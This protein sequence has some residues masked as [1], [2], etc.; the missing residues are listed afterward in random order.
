MQVLKTLCAGLALALLS[1]T[2][3]ADFLLTGEFRYVDRRFT[4]ANGFNGAE[5]ERV[6]PFAVVNVLDGGGSTLVQTQTDILGQISVVVPGSGTEDIS[7]RAFSRSNEYG[8]NRLRVTTTS[9]NVYSVTSPVFTNHDMNTDLDFGTVVADKVV[10]GGFE[11]GPF[12]ILDMAVDSIEYIKS[13]GA[14]NP[15]SQIRI[16][17]PGG[18]SSF[19][20]GFTATMAD[21]DG[22]DDMVILHEIGHVIHNMY[23]DSDSPG[24]SHFFGDSDQDPRLSYGEGWATFFAGAVR[25]FVGG[26]DVGFYMDADGGGGTGSGTI[27]LRMRH[28]NG[29]PF[30]NS[31]GG[32]ADEGAVFVTLWDLV[33][34]DA[35]NDPFAGDDDPFDG[36]L[37]FAGGISGDQMQWNVFTGPVDSASNLTI[38]N[39]WNG[40]FTP[41]DYGNAQ[42]LEDVFDNW[43]M[44][45]FNDNP[46][47]NN[48][49]GTATPLAPSTGYSPIRTLYFSSVSPGG[50]GD[51]DSDFF[52]FPLT[53]G[54]GFDIETRYP[55]GQGDAGTYCDT[56]LTVRRPNGTV[57]A[58]DNDSGAGRNARLLGQTADATGTWTAQVSSTHSYRRTGSYQIRLMVD[59]LGILDITPDTVPVVTVDGQQVTVEGFGFNDATSVEVDGIL[60][61]PVTEWQAVNDFTLTFDMPLATQMGS[62]DVE[63]NSATGAAITQMAI[64][65]ASPPAVDM[66]DETVDQAIGFDM[67]IGSDFGDVTFLMVSGDLIPSD[68]SPI[69][70]V[71][72]GNAGATL[73]TVWTPVINAKGWKQRLFGPLS[74]FTLGTQLHWQSA[75]ARFSNGYATP[76][77]S[78]NVETGTIVN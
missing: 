50:P 72:I 34:T 66:L 11:G 12:N 48:T 10:S 3:Q 45:F 59:G 40:Q 57:F 36:T 41:V 33:D 54:D 55:Q 21:D 77:V 31:T 1:G 43:D 9:N 69:F 67:V 5:P 19:A 13:L 28:E 58:T 76:W 23:S 75:T 52:S 73:F 7:V 26:P 64:I 35:T 27:Q 63:I 24:G 8:T 51:G 62:V 39:H 20:S 65:P 2:A 42:E 53:A 47:P 32:E 70:T 38:R 68:F 22:F 29:D 15:T 49:V 46:E 71:D 56:F 4:F 60:L 6:I 30:T 17:W 78:S 14:S 61:T 18:G 25:N 74:G 37:T 44:R 16:N